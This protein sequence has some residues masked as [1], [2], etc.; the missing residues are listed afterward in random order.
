MLDELQGGNNLAIM[1]SR[2]SPMVFPHK[3]I[4]Y[5]TALSLVMPS[6][7]MC[8]SRC[9]LYALIQEGRIAA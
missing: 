3:T 7:I 8:L 5:A 2:V 4:L 9:S 6:F 1:F